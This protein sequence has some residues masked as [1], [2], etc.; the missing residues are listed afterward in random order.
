VGLG[1]KRPGKSPVRPER[2]VCPPRLLPD[3]R[4]ATGEHVEGRIG[5][6]RPGR[7]ARFGPRRF[8]AAGR[9]SEKAVLRLQMKPGSWPNGMKLG[10]ACYYIKGYGSG[11]LVHPGAVWRHYAKSHAVMPPCMALTND[12]SSCRETRHI[13][14]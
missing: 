8:V 10:V 14:I 4:V 2:A 9:E 7:D 3:P 6:V 13:L 12:V 1:M 5:T 11:C